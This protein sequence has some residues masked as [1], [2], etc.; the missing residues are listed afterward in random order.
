M[1]QQPGDYTMT[2]GDTTSDIPILRDLMKFIDVTAGS[3]FILRPA[4][5]ERFTRF[6][7]NPE[8]SQGTPDHYFFKWE[9]TIYLIP[10]PNSERTYNIYHWKYVG[11][12]GSAMQALPNDWEEILLLAAECICHYRARQL[13][14]ANQ[15][16]ARLQIIVGEMLNEQGMKDPDYQERVDAPWSRVR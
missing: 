12:V 10:T 1:T 16:E 14:F 6:M 7:T 5:E 8:G 11:D 3:A 4:S 2:I 13:E 9:D 15:C